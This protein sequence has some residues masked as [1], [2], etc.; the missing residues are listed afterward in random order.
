MKLSFGAEGAEEFDVALAAMAEGEGGADADGFE[1]AG[2]GGEV[3][4]ELLGG[5]GAEGL[6]EMDE[7]CQI[8]AQG[9]QRPQFFGR[10]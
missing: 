10:E 8:N 2:V 6:V 4:D 5:L 1:A 3:A 9:F 7:A